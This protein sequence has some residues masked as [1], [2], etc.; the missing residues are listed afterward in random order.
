M[1]SVRNRSVFVL[2]FA[3]AFISC[4]D[5]N[6]SRT[7]SER[8]SVILKLDDLWY[9]EGLVH[10][11]WTQVVE[12]LNAEGVLGTIGLVCSSLE[13]GN[14][15]YFQ[16]IKDRESEGYEI[17]HH[18]YCHCKP[19]VDQEEKREFRGTD[20]TYQLNHL[21]KSQD[22][23]HEKLDITFRSFGAPYNATDEF[24]AKALAQI[25]EIQ[26]W[27]YK[28][29]KAMTDKFVLDRIPEVNIEYPVHIPDFKKLKAGYE[30]FHDEPILILQGHPRSW[31]DD[32]A[33][34]EEFT[35]IVLFLKSQKVRFTTPYTY[36][37]RNSKSSP[38]I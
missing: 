3:L 7:K 23:A 19:M 29:S 27:M 11:G 17:W 18:G 2:F 1:K 21:Q 20:Y 31:V 12:F 33:R 38:A 4:S 25:P 24:T 36:F 30:K 9:E 13:E 28:D 8:P 32:P 14:Q 34:F 10:P 5:Q 35:R 37:K 22:L 26:I 16:W 15:A 6:I